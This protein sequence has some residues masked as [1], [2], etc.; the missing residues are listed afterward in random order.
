MSIPNVDLLCMGCFKELKTAETACPFCGYN[1]NQVSP[2]HLLKPRSILN[3]KYI[4]GKAIGEGGFGITYIGMELN[5]QLK[6]AIK[7]YYPSGY[8]T[9]KSTVVQPTESH[10]EFFAKGCEHFLD[11]A[12]RLAKFRSMSGIVAV[13]DFFRENGTA[14]IVME[15][16]EGKT[17]NKYLSEMKGKLP[18]QMI[19]D[20]V[21]P[22]IISLTEVHK[23]GMIHRDIS[24]DN[25]MIS[26]NGELKLLDFGAARE[27]TESGNKSLSV[28]LKP[29][30]APEE[31]Y[32]SRGIQG[33]WTD[34]Y[35]LCATIYKCITGI[36]PNESTGRIQSDTVKPPSSIGINIDPVQEKALMKGMAVLQKDR[37][38]NLQELYKAL[39]PEKREYS[40]PKQDK[41]NT[42]QQD[43]QQQDIQPKK[44]K[45]TK[46]KTD[47]SILT[48]IKIG[49]D[50]INNNPKLKYLTILG[51]CIIIIGLV[52]LL[53]L[54]NKDRNNSSRSPITRTTV[55]A[56]R[57]PAP[58]SSPAP[59]A[60]SA[61]SPSPSPAPAPAPSQPVPQGLEYRNEGQSVRITRYTGNASTLTIPAE[62]QNTPVTAIDRD[63]FASRANLSGITIPNSVTSIGRGA[64]NRCDN[65]RSVTLGNGLTVIEQDTFSYC[66]NLTN[67]TIP[68]SVTS[69]GQEAF[70]RC[71]NLRSITLGNRLTSIGRMAFNRCTSLSS[72]TIPASVTNIDDLAF[73]GCFNLT[74]VTFNG[75]NTIIKSA[76]SFPGDL[77]NKYKSGGAGTY[78]REAEKRTWTKK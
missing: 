8:A 24:P 48:F 38:Q 73:D 11:E 50:R 66:T 18:A 76:N 75:T 4:V 77:A 56:A 57:A 51:V 63:A 47:F 42:L 71:E 3:G 45:E 15:Y 36:T 21:K 13:S 6:V 9:R 62:I 55:P 40:I 35:A 64:F 70:N 72:I 33:P 16:I 20:L 7:E 54:I 17:L 27:Y 1:E 23:S 67:I 32:R 39:Y 5:L 14:Y 74:S 60:D 69:I 29:G 41:P 37:F 25:I 65:L 44:I 52:L 12:R 53:T 26:N 78:T 2:V 28:V 34:I 61:P 46:P 58:S 43:I 30:Y 59:A 68:N 49:F 19:F 10:G 31:Q 22:V